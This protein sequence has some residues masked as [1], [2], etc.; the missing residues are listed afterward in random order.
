MPTVSRCG[1][2][3]ERRSSIFFP[4]L[5]PIFASVNVYNTGGYTSDFTQSLLQHGTWL[6]NQY[7]VN[8]TVEG[9]RFFEATLS[10]GFNSPKNCASS[11]IY[12]I[13]LYINN[14]GWYCLLW[15]RFKGE[16]NANKSSLSLFWDLGM[17]M[18]HL[19]R[20]TSVTILR[21]LVEKELWKKSS[22]L[23]KI[24]HV[25]F[26]RITGLKI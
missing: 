15:V 4:E 26:L 8:Q 21:G 19:Y 14:I 5:F 7:M 17:Q 2:Y 11:Q 20:K 22:S 6:F 16:F 3:F 12:K 10:F 24:N 13:P 25:Y 9:V 18:H 1:I 23:I